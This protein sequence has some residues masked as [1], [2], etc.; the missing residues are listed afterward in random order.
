MRTTVSLRDD[1]YEAA[2]R[3]AYEERRTFGSVVNDLIER[4]LQAESRSEPRVLGAYVGQI[5]I[6]DDFDDELEDF[7]AALVEPVEP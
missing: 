2:R 6:A 5:T 7:T 1:L 4:G 3:R